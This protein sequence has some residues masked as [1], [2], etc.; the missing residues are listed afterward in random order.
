MI[1]R[2][3]PTAIVEDQVEIGPGTSVWHHAHLR[4]GARIGAQ[5]IVGDRSYVAGG[6]WIGDRVKIHNGVTIASLVTIEDGVFVGAGASFTNDR[7]PRAAT[8][9]LQ[10]LRSS[11]VDTHIRPTRICSGASIGSGCMIGSDL[12]I[13]RFAMVGMGSVITRSVP[14]FHLV[15]GNPGR[16]VGI[17][18]RC[19]QPVH[20]FDASHAT[21]VVEVKCPA[22]EL[23]YRIDQGVVTELAP[24]D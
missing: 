9:D 24:P 7:Y 12:V 18:C 22:C 21:R 16:S 1:P 11:D 14:E 19:G 17:V 8:A 13:G 23:P 10:T 5:C 4:S 15:V 20:R 2:I 3:H 6:A